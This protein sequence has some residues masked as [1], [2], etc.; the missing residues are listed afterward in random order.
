MPEADPPAGVT[1]G[2]AGPLTVQHVGDL[3]LTDGRV[4][5]GNGAEGASGGVSRFVRVGPRPIGTHLSLAIWDSPRYGR[6]VAFAELQVRPG[7]PVRWTEEPQLAI[8]TDGGDGAFARGGALGLALTDAGI[9]EYVRA[10][11]AGNGL[12]ALTVGADGSTDA[13]LFATGLGDGSYPTY[14]GWDAADT[15]V[16]IVHDGRLVRWR[17]SGLPGTPP[18]ELRR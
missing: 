17:D 14:V 3:L 16:S 7:L 1:T 11:G 5:T 9:D 18:A 13:V 12:C 10:M 4:G 8:A 15:I 6:R 2:L